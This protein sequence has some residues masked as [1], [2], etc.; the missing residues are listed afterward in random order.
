MERHLTL[1]EAQ[2]IHGSSRDKTTRRLCAMAVANLIN[3]AMAHESLRELLAP[4]CKRHVRTFEIS[5]KSLS[6]VAI[7]AIS[8]SSV[9]DWFVN[10]TAGEKQ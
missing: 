2:K 3:K 10:Q 5:A 9:R 8:A 7:Q 4:A 6:P 1:L